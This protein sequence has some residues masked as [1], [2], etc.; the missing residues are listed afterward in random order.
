MSLSL[1]HCWKSLHDEWDTSFAESRA[2]LIPEMVVS[3][4]KDLR[5]TVALTNYLRLGHS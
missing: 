4:S 5:C 1:P 2:I 3:G